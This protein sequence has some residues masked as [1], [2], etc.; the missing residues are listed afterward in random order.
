LIL[1]THKLKKLFLLFAFIAIINYTSA[2]ELNCQIQVTTQQ[3]SITD[4]RV[5]DNLK[6]VIFEF[7]NNRKWTTETFK[8]EERIDCSI[9]LNITERIGVDEFNATLQ[10]QARRPVFSS[11]YNTVLIN[12]IDND[13]HFKYAETTALEFS[14][15]TYL[16]NLTSLLSYY[17]YLV[18]GLD[19]DS[20]ALNGG[21]PY[22]QKAF[23]ITNNAQGSG[24]KGW[25]AF[26]G[27]KNR[28]WII[29]NMLDA[30]FITLRQTM[31]DYHR[32]GLDVMYKNTEQGRKVIMESLLALTKVHNIKQLSFSLQFFFNAKA[33]EIINIFT[34]A[35]PEDKATLVETLKIIDPSRSN[36]YDK[37]TGSN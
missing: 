36:K 11:S 10:I 2:Q 13:V 9:L 34:A 4:K 19:Y 18:I 31:Y 15:T 37:I 33:D 20:Y 29:A 32:N 21:T 28:Y 17:A 24:E 16:S 22:F 3:I 12:Y 25:K 14:E 6:T 5:F 30:P 26:D 27:E 8:N 35:K 23:T 7:M 1:K